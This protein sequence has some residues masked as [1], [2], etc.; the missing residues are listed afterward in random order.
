MEAEDYYDKRNYEESYSSEEISSKRRLIEILIG[1]IFI[2]L[3]ILIVFLV[4]GFSAGNRTE[5]T[6]TNSY[7]TYNIYNNEL[8]QPTY[9]KPYIV[10]IN[11][12]K[13]YL[14]NRYYYKQDYAQVYYIPRDLRY[15]EPGKKPMDYY[16]DAQLKTITGVFGND[17]DRYEV[18]VQNREYAGGY[19]KVVFY[20]ED[21]YGK[22][23]SNSMTEYIPAREEKLF[24][25]KDISPDR[26]KYRNWWYKVE[27]L[28]KVPVKVYYNN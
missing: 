9:S 17:I 8:A 21:Y 23:T 2:A 16:D 26:Y 22:T 20:F 24:L 27:S 7:N 11:D 12:K 1:V 18:Y 13:D 15:A 10:N 5:T 25:F 28:S 3:L 14:D 6:I 19:F 4:I